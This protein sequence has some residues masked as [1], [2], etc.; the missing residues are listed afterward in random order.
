MKN[1]DMITVKVTILS[2][3]RKADVDTSPLKVLSQFLQE[4][5]QEKVLP[6]ADTYIVTNM[7]KGEKML[8]N[9]KTL[10]A[11]GVTDGDELSIGM[12]QNFG[13]R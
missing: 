7:S 3:G 11:N 4:M 8:D 1:N 5:A 9:S 10:E 13:C 2:N 6:V 12:G